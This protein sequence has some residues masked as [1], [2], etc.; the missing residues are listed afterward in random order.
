MYKYKLRG[1]VDKNGVDRPCTIDIDHPSL[2]SAS[3][4]HFYITF[5]EASVLEHL[6]DICHRN[7]VTIYFETHYTYSQLKEV[8]EENKNINLSDGDC[9]IMKMY[10]H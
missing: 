10:Y 5:D 4:N 6:P 8:F 7:Y 1:H 9:T 2:D 3:G